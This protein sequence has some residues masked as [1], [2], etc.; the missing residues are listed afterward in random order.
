MSTQNGSSS[1]LPMSDILLKECKVLAQ[2][3]IEQIG[4]GVSSTNGASNG[5]SNGVST[6]SHDTQFLKKVVDIISEEVIEKNHDPTR[7]VDV[8]SL[9]VITGAVTNV[10]SRF[11]ANA[12]KFLENLKEML[13]IVNW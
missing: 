4:N 11:D 12:S 2:K 6:I 1:G 8:T 10:F 9:E 13:M 5:T 7:F 3:K